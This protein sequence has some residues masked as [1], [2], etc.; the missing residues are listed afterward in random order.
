MG[1]NRLVS[2]H[3]PGVFYKIMKM[4]QELITGPEPDEQRVIS[5]LQILPRRAIP[6]CIE[7]EANRE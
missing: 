4:R 5:G 1:I 7:N 2:K 3:L 6:F